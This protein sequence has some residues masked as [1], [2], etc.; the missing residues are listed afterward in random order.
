MIRGSREAES[1]TDVAPVAAASDSEQHQPAATMSAGA[2]PLEALLPR[3]QPEIM[4][5]QEVDSKCRAMASSESGSSVAAPARSEPETTS[6][7]Q[8][9]SEQPVAEVALHS[10]GCARA[11]SAY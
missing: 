6:D 8:L 4:P 1:V 11:S 7:K 5:K 3:N 9:F 10:A 2:V